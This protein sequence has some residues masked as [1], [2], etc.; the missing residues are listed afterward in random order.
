MATRPIADMQAYRDSLGRFVTHTGMFMRPVFTAA[1]ASPRR[2]VYA[3]GEDVRVLRAAQVAVDEGL[4]RPILIG[5]PAVIESRIRRA[6]SRLVAGRDF[7]LIDADDDPCYRQYW[8]AY[9]RLHG[10]DGV[11]PEIAKAA[12]CRSHTAIG[13]MM[14]RLGDADAMLCGLV[15]RFEAHLDRVAG[16]IG[17]AEGADR[18]CDDERADARALHAVHRRY[19]G[20]R[21][22]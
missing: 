13:A 9:H 19:L 4:A 22:P 12:L 10:R 11:T 8:E 1:K 14:I 7:E 2:V 6:G 16:I 15:G 3:E 5:R 18:S 17:L 21:R 20:Q